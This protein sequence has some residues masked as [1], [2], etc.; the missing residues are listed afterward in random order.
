MVKV[1]RHFQEPGDTPPRSQKPSVSSNALHLQM[2]NRKQTFLHYCCLGSLSLLSSFP[3]RGLRGARLFRPSPF[4]QRR[5]RLWEISSL[6]NQ[7]SLWNVFSQRGEQPCV[8]HLLFPVVPLHFSQATRR[9]RSTSIRIRLVSVR[10]W[11]RGDLKSI[12][13]PFKPLQVALFP[14]SKR[15]EN[16]GSKYILIPSINYFIIM[17]I[18]Q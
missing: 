4:T 8:P 2:Q 17:K 14:L 15:K 5:L 13:T 1:G 10:L 11:R 3:K 9:W 18:C 16:L 12:N 7:G 6:P